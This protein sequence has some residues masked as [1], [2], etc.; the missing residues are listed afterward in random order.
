MFDSYVKY[1]SVDITH[2]SIYYVYLLQ[3][4]ANTKEPTTRT[5]SSTIIKLPSMPCKLEVISCILLNNKVYVTGIATDKENG[6]QLV[7]VYSLDE[8]NWSTLPE[9]PNYNAPAAIID[10]CVTLIGGR[11]T[12]DGTLTKIL[13]SW[14]EEECRWEQRVPPM[15]TVRLE[16]GVCHHD[17]LLLVTGGVV[18]DKGL[19]NKVVD[20]VDVYNFS[21]KCWSTPKALKLPKALRSHH[22]LVLEE[23]I[24]LLAGAT[25][26]PAS[27]AFGNS[28]A[29]KAQW[30]DVIDAVKQPSKTVEIVWTPIAAPAA[31]RPTVVSCRNSLFAIGGA[32]EGQPQKAIYKFDV[33]RANN[34][35]IEVGKL[36]EGRYLH[37][38]VPLEIH[39]TVCLL[40]VVS[41]YSHC[42]MVGHECID[43]SSSVELVP[44]PQI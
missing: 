8:V 3:D 10:G 21:T 22:L 9:T 29:W 42:E 27:A 19:V 28:E 18:E 38:V 36:S 6:S 20:T 16:S 5:H 23:Q 7:Q 11:L 12:E 40:F 37:G 1:A 32:E 17:N 41:G 24:Y 35:W 39:A 2:M 31:L 30:S 26:Y 13:C 43:K 25:R 44:L 4:D 34:L 33:E 15:P 14:I